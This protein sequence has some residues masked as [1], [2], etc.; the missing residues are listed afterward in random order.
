MSVVLY[1]RGM[2]VD[3]LGSRS[4]LLLDLVKLVKVSR[5]EEMFLLNSQADDLLFRNLGD[6]VT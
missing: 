2:W 5:S 3:G 6:L 1:D 4:H